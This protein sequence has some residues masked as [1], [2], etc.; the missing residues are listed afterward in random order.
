MDLVPVRLCTSQFDANQRAFVLNAVGIRNVIEHEDERIVLYVPIED[1]AEAARQLAEYDEEEARRLRPRP[2]S[3]L[4]VPKI[5]APLAY[6]A[7]MTFFFVAQQAGA[8]GFDWLNAGAA[9]V[10]LIVQGEWWRTV[11][12]LFLHADVGHLLGNLGMGVVVGLLLAQMLGSGVAW[13]AMLAAGIA[14]NVLNAAIQ[15]PSHGAIGASTAVFGGIGLLAGFTQVAANAPWHR[16]ARKWA[17]V[18]AGLALLVLMGTAGENTDVW[19]HVTGFVAGGVMGLLLGKFGGNLAGRG[20]LQV[21]AALAIA[22]AAG[23]AW[24]LALR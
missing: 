18:G 13:F 19:A 3:V 6:V 20:R 5:E 15:P 2:R 14:G 16:G 22:A 1:A 7:V 4:R 12:S 11:T 23:A 17:P 8:F 9:R 21:L 24:W 10:G